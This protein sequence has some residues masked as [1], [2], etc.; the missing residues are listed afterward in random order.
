MEN[1]EYQLPQA[2]LFPL[3]PNY[4]REMIGREE[5]V[6]NAQSITEVLEEANLDVAV[7]SSICGPQVTRYELR[8]GPGVRLE[9]LG[10]IVPEFRARLAPRQIRMLLPIP[11]RDRAGI[12]VPNSQ[13][14]FWGCGEFFE[15]RAWTQSNA[16]IPLL[17]GRNIYNRVTV[18]DLT[19]APHLLVAGDANTGKNH[20]LGQFMA[21][22]MMRFP[23]DRLRILAFDARASDLRPFSQAPHFVVPPANSPAAG[24]VLLEYAAEVMRARFQALAAA[25]AHNV[26]DYNNSHPSEAFCFLVVILN[27]ISPLLKEARREKTLNLFHQLAGAG[28]VG[29]HLIATT[30]FPYKDNFPEEVMTCFPW[31]IALQTIQPG[32]SMLILDEE[33]AETLGGKADFLLRDKEMV[34][35]YQGGFIT[36][37]EAR[38]LTKFCANQVQYSTDDELRN[39]MM[40]AE[41][42]ERNAAAQARATA[43]APNLPFVETPPQGNQSSYMDALKAIVRA[44]LAT[45]ELLQEQLGVDRERAEN[46]LDELASHDYLSARQDGT[47]EREIRYDKLPAEAQGIAEQTRKTIEELFAELAGKVAANDP[48]SRTVVEFNKG[49]HA[50]GKKIVEE[51]AEVWMAAEFEDEKRTVEEISQLIYHLLV[52]M[53]RKKCSLEDLYRIL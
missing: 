53:L 31:R 46:L 25:G 48:Q 42:D 28:T 17:L 34:E 35:R 50:I 39:A 14:R 33:G 7:A 23:P 1:S 21:S 52:M 10:D 37:D 20:L 29:I 9:D 38:A 5:I 3:N 30:E 6:Q 36:E 22:M 4:N 18:M 51:A 45:P 41:L 47:D 2:S 19:T 24:A 27:E 44:R 40:K 15:D 49:I 8:L 32:A 43:Q 12:E 16:V 26:T 11:G 13:R